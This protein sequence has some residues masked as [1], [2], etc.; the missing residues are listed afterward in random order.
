[1]ESFMPESLPDNKRRTD[2]RKLEKRLS[3][4][5]RDITFL[6][7]AL[8]HRSYVNQKSAPSWN[9]MMR[10]YTTM[11]EFWT[12]KQSKNHVMMGSIDA[13]FYKYITGIQLDEKNPAFSSF[14][15]RPLI[16]ES[17]G[18][19][20]AKIETI[21]GTISSAWQ[22][23]NGKYTIDVEVPFNSTAMVYI[24]VSS[25]EIIREGGIPA[26][27]AVGVEAK[28]YKNGAFI[29]KVH[30]GSYSFSTSKN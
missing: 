13:W 20:R 30:S 26:E 2:L 11:C 16:L 6:A 4:N 22:S 29:F 24:P 15:V 12:L 8:T 27:K 25:T 28:G 17:L 1:M 23:H 9:D 3:Y 18:S 7:T 21:R 10:K 14:V 19:A 5:F